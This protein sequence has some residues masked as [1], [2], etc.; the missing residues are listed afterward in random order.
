M[1]C[2]RCGSDLYSNRLEEREYG[3]GGWTDEMYFV[4]LEVSCSS[5]RCDFRRE[6]DT[7]ELEQL[8]EAD[9]GKQEG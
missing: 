3:Y 4:G 6:Y 1:T 8:A 7:W 2:P 5:R 9:A